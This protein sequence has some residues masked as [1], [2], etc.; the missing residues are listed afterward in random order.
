MFLRNC[1]TLEYRYND[2][3]YIDYYKALGLDNTASADDIKKAYRKLAR[4]FHPDL[5][6]DDQEA[7][8]RFQEINEAHEV[9]SDP[10][11]RKKYDQYGKNWKEGEAYEKARS[12]SGTNRQSGA[13]GFSGGFSGGGEG[14]GF[15]DYDFSDFFSSMF[16]AGGA[17]GA[18]G[19]GHRGFRGQDIQAT[20]PLEL[21]QAYQTHKQVF[22]VNDKNIRI[23]IPAGVQDGQVIR[24]RGHGSPGINGGPA[25]DLYI[26]FKIHPDA[27]FQRR[28]D[29]LYATQEVSLY[30]A[31][32]GGEVLVPTM[33]GQVKLKVKPET[34]NGT[35][36]KLSG[37]G[38]TVYKKDGNFGDL[39]I[40]YKVLIPT[41]LTDEEKN[42]FIQLSKINPHGS[43]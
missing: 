28:G 27:H 8:K 5:N 2:M 31:V 35:K 33:D 26:T 23:T 13:G 10:E 12:Q 14:A 18:R 4:K 32:L 38:F 34:Q 15:D 37:K 16:G 11:K 25:G 9:L 39:F 20:F 21:R 22:T 30:V 24:L 29:D 41:H 6:P 1:P 7:K 40:T 19:T 43:K 42:L 17:S 3:E 36:V